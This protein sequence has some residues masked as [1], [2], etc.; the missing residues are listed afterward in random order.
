MFP[1]P[2]D[3]AP[4]AFDELWVRNMDGTEYTRILGASPDNVPIVTSVTDQPNTVPVRPADPL[5][6]VEFGL[7]SIGG[8]QLQF[9][10]ITEN[11]TVNGGVHGVMEIDASDGDIT[12]TIDSNADDGRVFSFARVDDSANMVWVKTSAGTI[13]GNPEHPLSA[14]FSTL[15]VYIR[16]DD[17]V[18]L[19]EN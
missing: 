17:A 7:V 2:V 11:Q 15:L 18:I 5:T 3:R 8:L 10:S 1:K 4:K 13:N 9:S 16:G 12:V 14:K 19:S 6:P